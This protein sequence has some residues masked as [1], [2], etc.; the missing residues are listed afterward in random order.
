M[1]YYLH[2]ALY[3][4]DKNQRSSS[5][6]TAPQLAATEVLSY[7]ERPDFN[8]CGLSTRLFAQ[9]PRSLNSH[10]LTE[11]HDDMMQRRAI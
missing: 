4:T 3:L 6:D 9:P 7:S 5:V 11:P 1:L 8:N 10:E 2:L